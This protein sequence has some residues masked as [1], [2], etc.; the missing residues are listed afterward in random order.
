MPP[1]VASDNSKLS[2]VNGGKRAQHGCGLLQNGLYLFIDASDSGKYI[3][4]LLLSDGKLKQVW[5]S[6]VAFARHF[7]TSRR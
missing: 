1:S 6:I 3:I 2:E 4:A 7:V 5:T